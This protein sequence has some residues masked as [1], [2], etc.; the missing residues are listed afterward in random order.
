[1]EQDEHTPLLP[2]SEGRPAHAGHRRSSSLPINLPL[3]TPSGSTTAPRGGSIRRAMMRFRVLAYLVCVFALAWGI[4]WSITV[5]EDYFSSHVLKRHEPARQVGQKTNK[6]KRKE[7][8][9]KGEDD[10]KRKRN[11]SLILS[12]LF[13]LVTAGAGCVRADDQRICSC[14]GL[15][16]HNGLDSPGRVAAPHYSAGLP[17]WGALVNK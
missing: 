5:A 11:A 16:T 7:K 13:I 12:H 6:K 17:A 14:H 2:R 15:R 9:R 1:M 10:E 3:D 4:E 8:K